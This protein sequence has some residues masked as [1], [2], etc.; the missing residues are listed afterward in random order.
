MKQESTVY[1]FHNIETGWV[2]GVWW[3][4]VRCSRLAVC[5]GDGVGDVEGVKGRFLL[6]LTSVRWGRAQVITTTHVHDEYVLFYV[7]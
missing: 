3:V 2:S 4:I 5:D 1:Q 7:A 6:T